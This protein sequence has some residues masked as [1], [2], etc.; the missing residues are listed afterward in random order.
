MRP[1]PI[2]AI[3]AVAA[4]VAVSP[5][6]GQTGQYTAPG[7]GGRPPVD[8]GKELRDAVDEARWRLG[9]IRLEPWLALQ[10]LA[11]VE[12]EGEEGDLT[13]SAGAGLRAYLPVGS[14]IVFA[15]HALPAYTWWR[16]R[17]EDRHWGG[18]AGVGMFLHANR[19]AVE[20]E[21]TTSDLTAAV[22]PETDRRARFD[23]EALEGRVELPV[24]SHFA[25]FARAGRSEQ[26][27]DPDAGDAEE[28]DDLDRRD[29]W[30]EGGLR[31]YLTSTLSLGIGAGQDEAEFA[32]TARD[33]SNDGS[34]ELAELDWRRSKLSAGGQWQRLRREGAAGSEFGEFEGTVG[35]ARIGWS[36]RRRL[37]LAVYGLRGVGYSVLAEAP[38]FVEERLGGMLSLGVGSRIQTSFF[39]ESGELDYRDGG[40]VEERDSV[41]G[42]VSLPLG[43]RL[44]LTLAG[45]STDSDRGGEATSYAEWRASIALGDLLGRWF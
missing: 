19:L 45:R 15:A 5:I 26:T 8:T 28:F 27:A 38:F 20:L 21:A 36:P 34:Y 32:G 25:L 11:W 23:S 10:E 39:Y 6:V 2:L 37:T 17:T 1:L 13:A 4:A 29:S 14:R 3:A 22:T 42:S 43:R 44:D 12:P 16:D 41:G 9:P 35:S 40:P 31:W 24:G 7:A 18:R 33:R 30:L